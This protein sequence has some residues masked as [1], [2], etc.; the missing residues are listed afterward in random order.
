LTEPPDA[1]ILKKNG[2]CEAAHPV[3]KPLKAA[4]GARKND[5]RI[6]LKPLSI[7]SMEAKTAPGSRFN[8]DVSS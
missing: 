1:I 6:N 4:A 7:D 5:H 8:I 3:A 2:L